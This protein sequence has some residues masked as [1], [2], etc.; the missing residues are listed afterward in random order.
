MTTEFGDSSLST[1]GMPGFD[2]ILIIPQE[3]NLP[4]PK[5]AD[6]ANVRPFKSDAIEIQP[7]ASFTQLEIESNRATQPNP[8]TD[9][10][11]T[12]SC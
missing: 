12:F 8:S 4:H 6:A 10:V 1:Y 2:A 11:T 5:P 3:H 7:Q 9:N